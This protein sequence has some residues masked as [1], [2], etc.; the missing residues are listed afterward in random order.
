M[1]SEPSKPSLISSDFTLGTMDV[2][3]NMPSYYGGVPITKYILWIDDGAGNW[4]ASGT[5]FTTLTSLT[6]KFTSLTG[7]NTYGIRI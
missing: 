2:S 6:N 4:P 3:W 7:G 1:P 5:D